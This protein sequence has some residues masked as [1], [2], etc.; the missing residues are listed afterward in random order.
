M[1]SWWV[2]YLPKSCRPDFNQEVT[3]T[4]AP[5]W[6]PSVYLSSTRIMTLLQAIPILCQIEYTSIH[7]LIP[8]V[9]WWV[10]YLP[11]GCRPDFNNGLGGDS[12][13]GHVLPPPRRLFESDSNNGPSPGHSNLVSDEVHISVQVSYL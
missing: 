5:Y 7:V 11:K 1:D 10:P 4:V 6:S 2:P 8:M 3:Q 12:N 9:S 13:S